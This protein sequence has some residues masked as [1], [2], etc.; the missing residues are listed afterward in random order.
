MADCSAPAP[1]R[2]SFQDFCDQDKQGDDKSREDLTD[3][4]SSHDGDG[5][6]KLH[7]HAPLNDVFVRFVEYRE[8][9]DEGAN[10]ADASYKGTWRPAEKPNGPRRGCNE[11]NAIDIPPT[12]RMNAV[13]LGFVASVVC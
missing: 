5:H 4:Q 11:E 13:V 9:A 2:Q 7:R 8:T 12:H 1:D 10:Y 3:R 6:G